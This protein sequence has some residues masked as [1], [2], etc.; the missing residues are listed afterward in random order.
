MAIITVSRGTFSGG[1]ILAERL[2]E[3]L[4]YPCFSREEIMQDAAKSFGISENELSSAINAVSYTHLTLPT[5][6]IV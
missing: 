4:G 6:R 1:K 3:R 2:A 5:K